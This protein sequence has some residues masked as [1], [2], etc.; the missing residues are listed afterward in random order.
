MREQV[1]IAA[2][3]RRAMMC[4]GT[5]GIGI[6]ACSPRTE[7]DVRQLRTGGR[8]QLRHN[9]RNDSE[10]DRKKTRPRDPADGYAGSCHRKAA[11][12]S[13]RLN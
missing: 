10:P 13:E 4:N 8:A 1:A 3:A 11:R 9:G 12:A 5:T 6:G 2:V 7:R